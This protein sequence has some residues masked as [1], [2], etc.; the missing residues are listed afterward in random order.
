M[1]YSIGFKSR[2]VK[3]LTGPEKVSASALSKEVGV[4]QP[5]L[6]RWVQEAHTL[7]VMSASN[8]QP[9]GSPKS[10]R[11]WTPQ[12]KLEVVVEASSVPEAEMGEFLRGKGI[13]MVQLEEWRQ[14]SMD[15]AKEALSKAKK[16][17]KKLTQE[18]KRIKDLEKELLRKDRALAEVTALLALKKKGP[19]PLGGRGRRYSHVERALI[20]DLVSEAVDSGARQSKACGLLGI[21]ARTVQRWV[22]QDIGVDRRKGHDEAPKNKL[23]PEERS[24]VIEIA[25]SPEF[26]DVSPKQIVPRLAD[27]GR[28][29]ASESTFFRVL[30][31]EHLMKHRRSA[32][33]STSKRPREL[34]ATG[35][36]QVWTWDIT[37]LKSPVTGMFYYLYLVVDVFSRKIVAKATHDVE[38]QLKAVAMLVAACSTEGITMDSLTIHSDNGSPMRGAIMKATLEKLGVHQ[39][40]S[41]PGVSDDNPYS[42]SLFG[43][44][45]ARPEYPSGPFESLDAADA[46]AERMVF[47]Y[48]NVHRHGWISF[49]TPAQRHSGEDVAILEARHKL[50]EAA[51]TKN[52]E[53]W[54]GKTRNWDRKEVV[55]LNPAPSK[56]AVAIS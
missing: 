25:N 8:K 17:K 3:R 10:P 40:F 47:W 12:Q 35:P 2:M 44:L 37:Y 46:W 39:S 30:R 13:H 42:E 22:D 11:Q 34:E 14:L 36:N 20:I 43:T 5:T 45:K 49:V 28:F 18:G 29:V 55:T 56:Q 21:A 33:P 1:T 32:N 53:R 41:R 51:R 19:G 15:A 24:E 31:E 9:A 27:K 38:C 23:S 50:Y 7:P 6:S 54:S 26:R 4:S 52:P 16:P 48:N